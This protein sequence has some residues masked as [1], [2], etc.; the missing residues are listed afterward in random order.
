MS[1]I[2]ETQE[3]SDVKKYLELA[4]SSCEEQL[5]NILTM[6]L[7]NLIYRMKKLVI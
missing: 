1:E 5:K 4:K 7:A 2:D 6:C 3:L